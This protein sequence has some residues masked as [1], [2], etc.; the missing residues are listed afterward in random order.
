MVLLHILVTQNLAIPAV[1]KSWLGFSCYVRRNKETGFIHNCF[2]KTLNHNKSA[3]LYTSHWNPSHQTSNQN[4]RA[5]WPHDTD[6]KQKSKAHVA[7][8][9]F[10][11]LASTKSSLFSPK[12]FGMTSLTVIAWSSANVL[13]LRAINPVCGLCLVGCKWGTRSPSMPAWGCSQICASVQRWPSAWCGHS[14]LLLSGNKHCQISNVGG[15]I[16]KHYNN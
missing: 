12:Y 7:S 13:L 1:T 5:V 3:A 8:F 16:M 9:V 2:S 10:S 11:Q 4:I 6:L 15:L 14:H